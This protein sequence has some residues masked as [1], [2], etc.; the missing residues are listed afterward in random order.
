MNLSEARVE[1]GLSKRELARRAGITHNAVGYW[2]AKPE[3]DPHVYA[4][5]R[6]AAVLGWQTGEFLS[7]SPRARVAVLHPDGMLDMLTAFAPSISRRLCRRIAYGLVTCGAM[8]QK[9][10]PCRSKSEPR[11]R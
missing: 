4:V 1:R 8:T 3:L 7:R 9:G 2:E 6:M 11:R 10:T 5:R